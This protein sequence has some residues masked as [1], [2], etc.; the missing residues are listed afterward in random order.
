MCA[1]KEAERRE[2]QINDLIQQERDAET[3]G[4]KLL[5]T[6]EWRSDSYLLAI[7]V[8]RAGAEA[9]RLER[10]RDGKVEVA[11]KDEAKCRVRQINEE[12]NPLIQQERNAKA[13]GKRMLKTDEWRNDRYLAIEVARAGAE[14]ARLKRIR[15]GKVKVA[16]KE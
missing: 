3:E 6:D 2:R 5:E 9:A 13:E 11:G 7:E 14:A 8:T 10:I 1:S 12:Y 15:D 4:K 16:K